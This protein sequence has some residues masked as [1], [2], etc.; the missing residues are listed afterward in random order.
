MQAIDDFPGYVLMGVTMDEAEF[1]KPSR[2][3]IS[4]KWSLGGSGR[5]GGLLTGVFP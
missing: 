4:C 2:E 3:W 1:T 5:G